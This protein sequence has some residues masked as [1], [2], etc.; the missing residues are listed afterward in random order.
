M[1]LTMS[2]KEDNF[3]FLL[4]HPS[5]SLVCG[6]IQ[7]AVVVAKDEAS[8]R[9]IHPGRGWNVVSDFRPWVSS[10]EDVLVTTLGIADPT[11]SPGVIIA[12]LSTSWLD[13]GK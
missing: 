1:G 5:D 9:R 13:D 2:E 11:L 4:E 10:P 7:S 12:S 6:T 3:L 8:A